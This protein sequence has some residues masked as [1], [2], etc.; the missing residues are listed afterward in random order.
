MSKDHKQKA[1]QLLQQLQQS[2][3]QSL[4]ESLLANFREFMQQVFAH[5]SNRD[6]ASYQYADL[7]ALTTKMWRL[8]NAGD[9]IEVF[10][11]NVEELDWQCSHSVVCLLCPNTP[12]VIDSVRMALADAICRCTACFMGCSMFKEINPIS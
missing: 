1:A 8:L 6:I 12:F 7:K 11:P 2:F 10:N 3:E 5:A 4:P 9:G